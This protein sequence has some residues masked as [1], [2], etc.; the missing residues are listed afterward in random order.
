[1]QLRTKISLV[2]STLLLA[3]STM[4]EDY[5]SVQYIQYDESFDRA[6]ISSPSIELSKDF[7]VDYNLKVGLTADSVSGASPTWFDASSGASAYSRD[8][9]TH[10]D[11]VEYGYIK[12]DD[13]RLAVNALFT[14]RFASRDELAIGINYSYE[15]DYEARELSGEYLYYLGSSKNQSIS[16]GASYQSNI[17]LVNCIENSACDASSGAS[18]N[19]DLNVI[20]AEIG[21]TQIIN[22][23]ALAK[24]SLFGSSEDGYLSNPYMNV[25]RDNDA[26]S[27]F[28]S[29]VAESKPETRVSYGATLQ[30]TVAL[31]DSI[32][33]NNTYRY[34]GDDWDI[35]SHTISSELY[36]QINNSWLIGGGLRYYT[37][38]E[39]DFY[40]KGYFSDEEYAS[41]D[42]RM[43]SFDAIGYKASVDYRI[44][45]ELSANIGLNFYDQR[46]SFNATYYNI[47]LKYRF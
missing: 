2:A 5:V 4:A 22:Q 42:E 34:Y 30:Y 45:K 43:R 44:T 23:N 35:D 25:V 39:S 47:G 32:S 14:T 16:A 38:S 41:S 18:E 21:F 8:K 11:D 29:I 17:I 31:T 3:S 1:M 19:F 26:S 7:G 12:Y 15:N 36:Y 6:S 46:D 28:V 24:V 20:S 27:S 10:R 37:Q 40:S 33:S 13:D 9:N